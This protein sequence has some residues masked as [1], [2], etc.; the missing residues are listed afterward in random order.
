MSEDNPYVGDECPSPEVLS[1]FVSGTLPA[2]LLTSVADHLATCGV[3]LEIMRG[4]PDSDDSLIDNL[5]R[6][7]RDGSSLAAVTAPAPAADSLPT[8]LETTAVHA[9]AQ[10]ACLRIAARRPTG[11]TEE[12][13]D[14]RESGSVVLLVVRLLQVPLIIQIVLFNVRQDQDRPSRVAHRDSAGRQSPS[15]H[16]RKCRSSSC[17]TEK[18][19]G[20]TIE[21]MGVPWVPSLGRVA[22]RL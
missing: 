3:S 13:S 2:A 10:H 16:C 12:N 6:Y 15:E 19:T 9:V 20:G 5:R 18:R 17:L 4:L 11:G 14:S 1:G 7:V 22:P 8:R 21:D